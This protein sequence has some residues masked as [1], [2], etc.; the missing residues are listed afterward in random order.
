MIEPTLDSVALDFLWQLRAKGMKPVPVQHESQRG[1]GYFYQE[2]RDEEVKRMDKN[3]KKSRWETP[4]RFE[5]NPDDMPDKF[6]LQHNKK[7]FYG[8]KNSEAKWTHEIRL[9]LSLSEI[10]ADALM[11]WL[12]AFGTPTHRFPAP[13]DRT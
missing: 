5:L 12:E 9:A 13:K 8:F 4:P 3:F 10:E 6:V 1:S 11:Q 7:Y 2:G